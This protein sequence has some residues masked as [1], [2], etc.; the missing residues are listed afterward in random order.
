MPTIS[1]ETNN[2]TQQTSSITRFLARFS[3]TLAVLSTLCLPSQ[4][5]QPEEQDSVVVGTDEQIS[6]DESS[7]TVSNSSDHDTAIS[8]QFVTFTVLNGSQFQQLDIDQIIELLE[9]DIDSDQYQSLILLYSSMLNLAETEPTRFVENELSRFRQALSN[10]LLQNQLDALDNYSRERIRNNHQTTQHNEYL[11]N[12]PV[13]SVNDYQ[14]LNCPNLAD[15]STEHL[16]N[17]FKCP[18]TG[19]VMRQPVIASD[20]YTYDKQAIMDRL[21]RCF[22]SPVTGETLSSTIYPN[23]RLKKLLQLR[24]A[25]LTNNFSEEAD[26]ICPISHQEIKQPA[27]A[28]DGQVYEKQH[29]QTWINNHNTSPMTGKRLHSVRLYIDHCFNEAVNMVNHIL[30]TH[31]NDAAHRASPHQ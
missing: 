3:N 29:I 8:P 5:N 28:A 4:A 9:P 18:I 31:D 23:H 17:V 21:R 20:G 25:Q 11:P 26:N 2:N 30:S 6:Y 24:I 27:V 14:P 13:I 19:E 1:S 22:F 10:Y 12:A 15:R 16:E 7:D